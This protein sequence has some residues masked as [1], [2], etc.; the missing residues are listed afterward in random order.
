LDV[1][2]KISVPTVFA[3]IS[4]LPGKSVNPVLVNTLR[5]L[6]YDYV[7]IYAFPGESIQ[8]EKNTSIFNNDYFLLIIVL[9]IRVTK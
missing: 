9:T 2:V 4:I 7:P 5:R 6:S 1:T 8:I 3:S